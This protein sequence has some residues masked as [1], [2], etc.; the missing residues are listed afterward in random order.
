MMQRGG[1]LR[2]AARSLRI[3]A[4]NLSKIFPFRRLVSA[5]R[6]RL[7]CIPYAGGSAMLYR[8]W[9]SGLPGTIDVCPVEL[10]GRGVRLGEPL[11][12]E[13]AEMAAHLAAAIAE[14]PGNLPLA[15]FGHSMGAR[16][17]FEVG[18]RLDGGVDDRVDRRLVHLFASG[19][20]APGMRR[21]LFLDDPRP[22]AE[23][24]DDEFR[25]RLHHLGGTPRQVL[26]HDELM[27]HILPIVRA[28]FILIEAYRADPEA[29]LSCPIT[30]FAGAQDPGAAE[31]DPAMVAWRQR[32]TG[33][34]R[35]IGVDAG[36]FFLES[37]RA[38]L[39]R[40]VAN[41][42]SPWLA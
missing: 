19:S 39:L 10:P 20:P 31:G 33:T 12:T 28:D 34:S 40:E 37:H 5:P 8:N 3:F 11:I 4:M 21:D 26:E 15:L 23:L 14:L 24:N 38:D 36:H 6:L 35:I 41:D 32:T 25:R 17:A 29:R 1:P 18:R 2:P 22:S 16:I 7:V 13:M 9:A 30:A 42:L 27:A